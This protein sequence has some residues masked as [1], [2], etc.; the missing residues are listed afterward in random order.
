MLSPGPGCISFLVVCWPCE[1]RECVTTTCCTLTPRE[2]RGGTGPRYSQSSHVF[3]R[4][5]LDCS[6]CLSPIT[7]SLLYAPLWLRCSNLQQASQ[8]Q[9]A[10]V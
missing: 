3:F 10:S 2:G 4:D 5:N 7:L 8:H 9:D 1:N 6:L